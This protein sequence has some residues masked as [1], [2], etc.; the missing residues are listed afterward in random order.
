MVA[1][2]LACGGGGSST[3]GSGPDAVTIQNFAFGPANLTV[4]TGTTVTWTNADQST[5][6][7][8]ADD[9]S[10][11]AGNVAPGHSFTF[12]FQH[13]GSYAYHCNIHQYMRAAITVTG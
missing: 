4:A 13:A 2:L 12:R 3:G 11:D 7:V 5:H 6:T 10:F 1:S 9:K 8:T